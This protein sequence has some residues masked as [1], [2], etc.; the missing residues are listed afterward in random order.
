M[1]ILK[2]DN[3]MYGI[4]YTPTWFPVDLLPSP[5]SSHEL[6]L[7]AV[8]ADDVLPVRDESLPC[9]RHLAQGADEAVGVPVATLEAD[10]PGSGRRCQHAFSLSKNVPTAIIS[11]QARKKSLFS[12]FFRLWP[13]LPHTY[14]VPPVPVIGLE[15]AVHLFAN[16]SPKQLA[17]YGLS[18]REANFCPA[19]WQSQLAQVKHSRCHAS[20]LKVTPPEVIT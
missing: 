15:Q 4:F 1:S 10:E 20:F 8:R 5:S 18:P 9:H 3:N 19:S 14:L 2:Q 6:L 13:I 7:C 12:I 16:R 11:S 17:Q